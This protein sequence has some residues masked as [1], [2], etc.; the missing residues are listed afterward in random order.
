MCGTCVEGVIPLPLVPCQSVGSQ[1]ALGYGL[2]WQLIKPVSVSSAF[3]MQ[4]ST[5]PPC[6]RPQGPSPQS[7]ARQPPQNQ[8]PAISAWGLGLHP[9]RAQTSDEALSASSARLVLS[10]AAAAV[11]GQTLGCALPWEGTRHYKTGFTAP[12]A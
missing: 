7:L 11:E 4:A 1:Q 9:P 2:S 5:L 12:N 3:L 6:A 8:P 10:R